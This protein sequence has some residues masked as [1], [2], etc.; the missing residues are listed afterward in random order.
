MTDIGNI[1][2]MGRSLRHLSYK[3]A[4][5]V[6]Y[7]QNI[8]VWLYYKIDIKIR[9]ILYCTDLESAKRLPKSSLK[10]FRFRKLLHTEIKVK[11]PQFVHHFF[12]ESFATL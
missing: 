2:F 8:F 3:L 9:L 11:K 12:Y 4:D 7:G 5:S 6:I 1:S 10:K